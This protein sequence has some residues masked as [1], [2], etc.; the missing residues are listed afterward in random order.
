MQLSRQTCVEPQNVAINTKFIYV[1]SASKWLMFFHHISQ[2]YIYVYGPHIY[3]CLMLRSS[4]CCK[5]PCKGAKL[6][7]IT[8][9][10]KLGR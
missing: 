6:R 8:I 3:L 9:R 1:L 10:E 2:Y 4:K 5:S 7:G